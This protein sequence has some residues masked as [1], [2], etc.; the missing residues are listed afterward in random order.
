MHLCHEFF[1]HIL[2]IIEFL[3]DFEE[4]EELIFVFVF[5]LH[6]FEVVNHLIEDSNDVRE[7][8]DSKKKDHRAD[9]SLKIGFWMEIAEA[10]RG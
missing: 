9:N 5:R 10:N 1:R 8:H 7:Y 2:T 4:V 6:T 3:H